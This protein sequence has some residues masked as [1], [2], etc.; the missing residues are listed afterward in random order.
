LPLPE[1][2]ALVSSDGL[3]LRVVFHKRHGSLVS[4]FSVVGTAQEKVG[5]LI[6]T[7]KRA[8]SPSIYHS[9]FALMTGNYNVEYKIPSL[10]CQGK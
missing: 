4:S 3:G 10:A 8:N 2:P 9:A 6:L 5:N 1:E 7:T